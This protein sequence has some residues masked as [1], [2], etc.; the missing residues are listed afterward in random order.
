ME[1]QTIMN[2]KEYFDKAMSCEEY[3]GKLGENL[4]LHQRHYKKFEIPGEDETRIKGMKPLNILVLTEPWCG[5]SLAIFPVV[6]KIT[7]INDSWTMKILLRD[8]NLDLMDL[9][10][11]NGGRAVPLFFFLGEDYSL[12]FKWG[13]RPKA[14]QQIFERHRK[15]IEEGEVEKIEVIKKIRHFY[16]QDKG[17]AICS[18]LLTVFNQHRLL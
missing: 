15:E 16:A 9:Y 8:Q 12:I 1:E 18:E 6:R 5:D 13:P 2:F 11:T 3:V 14:S 10:L 4:A 17:K 7:E